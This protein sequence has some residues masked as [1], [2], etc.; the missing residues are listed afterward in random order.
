MPLIGYLSIFGRNHKSKL[1]TNQATN[2]RTMKNTDLNE[3][4][5]AEG[6]QLKKLHVIVADTIKEQKLIVAQL[7]DPGKDTL[8]TGQRI[9]DQV[10][11][12]GGS[13][14]FIII[15][16]VVLTLWILAN[17]MVIVKY[18]FDPYPFILMNLILSCV[19]ALQAPVIMMSQ[20][21]QE[22]KDRQ[23]A[24]NDYMINLKAEI[25]IRGLQEKMDLL[26]EEQIKTLFDIQKKQFEMLEEIN[27]KLG[28]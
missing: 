28:K 27:K 21:R 11:K 16:G 7:R 15:F 20:N 22:D 25:E 13:W 1:N 12:F 5:N 26:L 23:R 9:S 2:K 18:Q 17:V 4:L 3:L 24:E 8:T 19:A 14:K 10:A 6:E